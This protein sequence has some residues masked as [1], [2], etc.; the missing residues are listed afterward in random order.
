MKLNARRDRPLRRAVRRKGDRAIQVFREALEDRWRLSTMD[1]T[2]A[3]G[4]SWDVATK[5]AFAC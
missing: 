3:S 5:F 2:N 4:G 1:W